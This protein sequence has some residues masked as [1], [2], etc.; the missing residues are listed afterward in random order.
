MQAAGQHFLAVPLSPSNRTVALV[1]NFSIVRQVRSISPSRVN[2]PESA[3]GC[4]AALSRRLPPE[5]EKT[6]GAVDR[7]RQQFGFKWLGEEIVGAERNCAQGVGLAILPGQDDNLRFGG[8]CEDLLEQQKN[9]P[10]QSRQRAQSKIDGH[11][12]R[13]VTMKLS[14]GAFPIVCGQRLEFVERPANCVCSAGSS[15]TMSRGRSF[16]LVRDSTVSMQ[17]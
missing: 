7:Q 3:G 6:E 15:S 8:G 10:R 4:C 13:I 5:I 9:S 11:H 12:G 16:S 2:R 14:Q 17:I 1:L